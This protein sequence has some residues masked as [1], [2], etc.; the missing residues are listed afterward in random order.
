MLTARL[1]IC[2]VPD[3]TMPVVVALHVTEISQGWDS[4]QGFMLKIT[5]PCS[6]V[7]K[8]QDSINYWS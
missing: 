1:C 2:G 3:C 8:F 6:P 7:S 4:T 5:I